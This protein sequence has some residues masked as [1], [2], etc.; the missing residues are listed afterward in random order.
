MSERC[1]VTQKTRKALGTPVATY[2]VKFNGLT[3]GELLALLHLLRK[4]DTAVQSD[5]CSRF[6]LAIKTAGLQAILED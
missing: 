6:A 2:D 5:V 4:H 3:A 1:V